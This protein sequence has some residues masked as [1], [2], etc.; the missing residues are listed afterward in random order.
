MT[1]LSIV[2]DHAAEA[3]SL[4]IDQYT[5]LPRFTGLITSAVNR[6]QE[7]ENITW[8]VTNKRLL[9]YVAL[10]GTSAHATGEQL[11]AAGRLVGRGRNAQTDAVYLLYVRA[12]IFLN[13]SRSKRN[14]I[15]TLLGMVE[16]ALFSYNEFYPGV[17]Y[18]EFA[19]P[20]AALPTDLQHLAQLSATGGVR[21]FLVSSTN[22]SGFLFGDDT[23]GGTVDTVHGFSNEAES[24]GGYLAGIW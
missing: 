3:L 11:E 6:V 13:K 14:E 18:I 17:V 19:T 7:L 23:I 4:L 21:V 5:G 24:T 15:I 9:D 8:D 22:T 16:P 12:Q 10:D 1:D 2:S 20:T